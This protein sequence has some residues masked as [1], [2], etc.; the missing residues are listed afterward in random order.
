MDIRQPGLPGTENRE[1]LSSS[2]T[3]GPEAYHTYMSLGLRFGA[4]DPKQLAHAADGMS[5]TTLPHVLRASSSAM[6]EAVLFWPERSVESIDHIQDGTRLGDFA[7]L[8]N[9]QHHLRT[10]VELGWQHMDKGFTT[11]DQ[12]IPVLGGWLE[13]Q[14]DNVHKDLVCGEVTNQTRQELRERLMRVG[15]YVAKLNPEDI[16]SEGAA[17]EMARLKVT[18]LMML[19]SLQETDNVLLLP[20]PLRATRRFRQKNRA[21]NQNSESAAAAI[22]KR[23]PYDAVL[24]MNTEGTYQPV[25]QLCIKGIKNVHHNP[26]HTMVIGVRTQLRLEQAEAT[27]ALHKASSSYRPVT[28][29][30]T[31]WEAIAQRVPEYTNGNTPALPRIRTHQYSHLGTAD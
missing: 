27:E 6:R 1:R 23:T 18:L 3:L 7:L 19:G 26:P 30:A 29:V 12:Q 10:S 28:T 15:R 2:H 22:N 14:Y 9:A 5:N 17:S 31:V 24:C 11:V 21:E 25:V 16:S 8:D 13:A 4:P 20:A